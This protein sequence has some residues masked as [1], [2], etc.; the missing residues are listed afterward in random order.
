MWKNI[1][2]KGETVIDATCG[3][4]YDTLALLKMV[5]DESGKGCV[6]GLDIQSTALERTSSL[7]EESADQNEV[8]S[9]YLLV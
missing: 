2:Q 8:T 9:E 4:G 5:A 6:Y 3:N 7:L 1:V